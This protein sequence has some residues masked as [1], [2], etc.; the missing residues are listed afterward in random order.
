MRWWMV[1]VLAAAAGCAAEP[2]RFGAADGGRGSS[3]YYEI[4]NGGRNWGDIKVWSL[5]A[6]ELEGGVPGVEIGFRLRADAD[7]PLEFDA[8][9]TT[10][11]VGHDGRY[12]R[13]H[14]QA[15]AGST[16]KAAPG[17]VETFV[18]RF[19]LPRGLEPEDIEEIEVNWAVRTPAGRMTFSSVFVPRIEDRRPYAS[20]YGASYGPWYRYP[21][22][23]GYGHPHYWP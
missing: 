3:F 7:Q 8:A 9:A 19:P 4:E 10:A 5:G 1:P 15:P 18:L 16:L 2:T 11:E 6:R 12:E 17:A 23:W 14:P 22:Y 21:G 20:Y 13:V